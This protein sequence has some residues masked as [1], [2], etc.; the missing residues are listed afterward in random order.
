MEF[1]TEEEMREMCQFLIGT[2]LTNKVTKFRVA[3]L[4]MCQFLIGTVL[5][6]FFTNGRS[7]VYG[8]QFLIGTVLT[9]FTVGV[10]RLTK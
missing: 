1:S 6:N 7:D 4:L 8:C 10:Q 3:M 9:C 5:T 2:V